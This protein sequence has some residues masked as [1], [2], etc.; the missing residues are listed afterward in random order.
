MLGMYLGTSSSFYPCC[1]SMPIAMGESQPPKWIYLGGLKLNPSPFS[2]R[3]QKEVPWEHEKKPFYLSCSWPGIFLFSPGFGGNTRY[4][5]IC[6]ETKSAP[7]PFIPDPPPFPHPCQSILPERGKNPLLGLDRIH[8]RE[9][10]TKKKSNYLR[11]DIEIF[12]F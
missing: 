11:R 10:S 6:A 5:S 7:I 1:L 9:N 12:K 4:V 8:I 2:H 3:V